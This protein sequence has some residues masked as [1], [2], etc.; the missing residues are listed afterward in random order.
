MRPSALI[1]PQRASPTKSFKHRTWKP[2]EIVLVESLL[3]SGAT[4]AQIACRIG[5]DR[6][7]IKNLVDRRLDP[8]VR[9]AARERLIWRA[10]QVV[11]AGYTT[12]EAVDLFGF[13]PDIAEAAFLEVYPEL[14]D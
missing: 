3:A 12:A 8:S 14:T 11:T 10:K 9:E 1:R 2:R 4:Y 6:K 13:A 7:A 5:V